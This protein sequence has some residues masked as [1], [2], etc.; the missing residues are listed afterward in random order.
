MSYIEKQQ[1]FSLEKKDEIC[2]L[3]FQPFTL[4]DFCKLF[5]KKNITH[6]HTQEL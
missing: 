1:N 6:E 5:F 4:I 3:I 2:L